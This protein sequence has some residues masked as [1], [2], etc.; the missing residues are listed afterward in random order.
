MNERHALITGAG[1]VGAYTACKLLENGWRVTLL[2]R[3]LNSGYL[4]DV[5]KDDT[6]LTLLEVDLTDIAATER[7]IR[8]LGRLDSVV[9]TAALI[10][11][12][13]QEDILETLEINVAASLRL[14]CLAKESG[15]GRLVV[16][17]S[18]SVYADDQKQAIT[19]ESPLKTR[20]TSYYTASKLAL[21]HML[22]A[23][24]ADQQLPTIAL[25]PTVIYGYG[26]NL[27]G[28]V[29]SAAIEAQ[30][31][32][33]MRGD[34]VTVPDNIISQTE[35]VYV[36]DVAEAVAAAAGDS[37]MNELFMAY[38]VGSAET[39]TVEQLVETLAEIFPEA[40]VQVG[41]GLDYSV[42]PPRQSQPTE[43]TAM[44]R[45]LVPI[46]PRTRSAGF[47]AFVAELQAAANGNLETLGENK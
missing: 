44:L 16:V 12:R 45:D 24:A 30:V 3:Q 13:A 8:G 34:D 32:R 42:I 46:P 28:G 40:N 20:F 25:R 11:A 22:S 21:E 38:N 35:L 37:P 1:M 14:A 33:A 9:H 6:R 39:T 47:R 19:E 7:A 17:S 36:Q 26:P 41:R 2:D 23:F 4:S 5:I 27:G 43:L 31:L 15:A 29:G 18:W 10:A